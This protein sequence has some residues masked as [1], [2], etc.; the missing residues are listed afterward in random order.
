MFE[1][2]E[3]F[4]E[5]DDD[6]YMYG[7]NMFECQYSSKTDIY[8][9]PYIL[10]KEDNEVIKFYRSKKFFAI[11]KNDKLVQIVKLQTCRSEDYIVVNLNDG[12]AYSFTQTIKGRFTSVDKACNDDYTEF[13]RK[14]R[15]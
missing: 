14:N 6:T 1:T 11:Y 5:I 15:L 10:K 9:E 12:I 4:I 3:I 13:I 8:F 2:R 7:D